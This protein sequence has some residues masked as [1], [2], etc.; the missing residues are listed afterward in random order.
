VSKGLDAIPLERVDLLITL[1]GE[2]AE[3]CPVMP[4][5]CERMHWPLPDPALAQGDEEEVLRTF[6]QVRDDIR[7]RVKNLLS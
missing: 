1:C 4:H 6:R 2:A 5:V 3:S 7:S